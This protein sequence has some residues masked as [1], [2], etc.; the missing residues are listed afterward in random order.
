MN[1]LTRRLLLAS[2]AALP[3]ARLPSFSPVLKRAEWEPSKRAPQGS[4][5][6]NGRFYLSLPVTISGATTP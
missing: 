1:M 4:Y 5:V 2:I 3:A 6:F